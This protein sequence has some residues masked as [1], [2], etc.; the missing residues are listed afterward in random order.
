[1]TTKENKKNFP[2]EEII[3]LLEKKFPNQPLIIVDSFL[4][5]LR[6]IWEAK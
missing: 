2:I 5:R 1:M 3:D 6:E 4:N